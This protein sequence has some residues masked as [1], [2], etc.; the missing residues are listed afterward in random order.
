M[1]CVAWAR[2]FPGANAQPNAVAAGPSGRV[3]VAGTF[4]AADFG[5]GPLSDPAGS[6][7]GE[8]GGLGEATR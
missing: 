2:G 1:N 6:R 7:S 3:A 5:T 4:V 8:G